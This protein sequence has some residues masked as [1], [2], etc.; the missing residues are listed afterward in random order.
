MLADIRCRSPSGINYSIIIFSCIN[1]CTF[2][3]TV[4]YGKV[5][6]TTKRTDIVLL[7]SASGWSYSSTEHRVCNP[8]W[9]CCQVLKWGGS[10]L[11]SV[12]FSGGFPGPY[13]LLILS[14]NRLN[15]RAIPWASWIKTQA[16]TNSPHLS[17]TVFWNCYGYI[18]QRK[19]GTRCLASAWLAK[20]LANSAVQHCWNSNAAVSDVL[21]HW[22][23]RTGILLVIK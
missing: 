4:Q 3:A 18:S 2:L 22:R 21:R 5:F 11:C 14:G 15:L 8:N 7:L 6:T 16:L 13:D 20:F 12:M 23:P 10:S 17:R 19:Q 9:P 1:I